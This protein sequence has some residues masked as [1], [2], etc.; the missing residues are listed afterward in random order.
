V[1]D[2]TEV[3]ESVTDSRSVTYSTLYIEGRSPWMGYYINTGRA[4]GKANDI[5]V[6]YDGELLDTPPASYESIPSDKALV[7]VVDNGPFEAAAF[8]Y[9]EGEFDYWATM[10]DP[11]PRQY[12]LL[13]RVEAERASDYGSG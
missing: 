10:A 3:P 6:I 8:M 5:A 11:R 9:D 12:V 7:V 1:T 4:H 2:V 13:D